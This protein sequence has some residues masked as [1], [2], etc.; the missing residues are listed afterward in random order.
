MKDITII[1][2]LIA[3][4]LAIMLLFAGNYFYDFSI[5]RRKKEFLSNDPDLRETSS[6]AYWDSNKEWLQHQRQDELSIESFDDLKLNALYLPCPIAS[7]KTVILIHGYNSWNGSMGGF[8]QYYLE[9][10][11]Y[12]VLLPNLRGHGKSEGN[13]IGFG[14]HDRRDVLQW[15]NL[16]L[17]KTGD[18]AQIVLH[19]VSMGGAT[20]L[21]ASGEK[22]PNNVK[23]IVSD[24]AY[25]STASI[26]GYQMKRM[27]KLPNF[28]IIYITSFICKLRAG[29]SFSEASALKQVQNSNIPILF[30]HGSADKFVP[31]K[32]VY[33]LYE[34]ATCPKQLLIIEE[35]AHGTSFW[36]N[37]LLYK[38]NVES[39]FKTYI[40]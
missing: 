31:T 18:T 11:G 26:L 15:I 9:T 20:V 36:K 35:A 5:L 25:A 34:A 6:G 29:Y 39:F 10:L 7:D 27:F 16:I 14:W 3:V 2:L 32:M 19:G 38:D 22:L 13:Y 30:I 1:M 24:C 17:E 28:P 33:E 37:S 40:K 21:M 4:I 12:N 23:C 8:A